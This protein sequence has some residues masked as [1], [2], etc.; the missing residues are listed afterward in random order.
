MTTEANAI[1]RILEWSGSSSIHHWQAHAL[2][3]LV[4]QKKPDIKELVAL[5]KKDE[6]D[7]QRSCV[8]DSH[9]SNRD[10]GKM[11]LREVCGIEHVNAL[12]PKKKHEIPMRRFD[13]HLW[14]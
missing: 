6:E 10:Q 3:Q 14:R 13:R 9:P 4:A 12:A 8:P 1:D 2:R 5:C 7:D 11:C